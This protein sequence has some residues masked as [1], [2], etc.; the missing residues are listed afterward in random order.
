MMYQVWGGELTFIVG[1]KGSS[2]FLGSYASIWRVNRM[3]NYNAILRIQCLHRS[4][5]E[6]DSKAIQPRFLPFSFRSLGE[7][8]SPDG[9]HTNNDISSMRAREI[10]VHWPLSAQ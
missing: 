2:C 5:E 1:T 7:F 8:S 10:M 6:T 4:R 3:A 9:L